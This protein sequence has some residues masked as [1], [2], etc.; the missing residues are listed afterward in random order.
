MLARMASGEAGA[1]ARKEQRREEVR[2]RLRAA[3]VELADECTFN[4]LRV[5]RIAAEAGLS[6]SAFYFYYRDGRDLLMDVMRELAKALYDQSERWYRGTGDPR[7]LTREAL[8]GVTEI[9][10]AN[11]GLLSMMLEVAAYDEEVRGLWD[12]LVSR[13]FAGATDRARADQHSGLVPEEL[14]A[15]RHAEI[16]VLATER[17]LQTMLRQGTL[18]NEEIIDVLT[19]I[20]NRVLYS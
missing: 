15:R 8:A 7:E 3:I 14:D 11:I 18:S 1:R 10:A 19:S 17:Y 2:S 6:R 20:W 16:L 12:D 9:W 13:F 5:E 4:E